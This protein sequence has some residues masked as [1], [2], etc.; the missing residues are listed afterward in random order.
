MTLAQC[1]LS[2]DGLYEVVS[3]TNCCALYLDIEVG[4]LRPGDGGFLSA[5]Q[6][7]LVSGDADFW[8]SS[9]WTWY[10]DVA[11]HRWTAEEYECVQSLTVSYIRDFFVEDAGWHKGCRSNIPCRIDTRALPFTANHNTVPLGS[12]VM[13]LRRTARFIARVYVLQQYYGR[14]RLQKLG[15]DRFRF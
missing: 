10:P 6:L 8:W 7:R 2:Y 11:G 9:F 5:D 14:V 15:I 13:Y 12:L 1:A 4:C 3:G